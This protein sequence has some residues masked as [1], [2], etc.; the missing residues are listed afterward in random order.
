MT[1][2]VAALKKAEKISLDEA[3]CI[4]CDDNA[5]ENLDLIVKAGQGLVYKFIKLYGGVGNQ[6]MIQCAYEG[7]IKAAKRYDPVHGTRFS[8]WCS[9]YILGEIR[10]HNKK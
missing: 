5:K 9:H 10:H 4:Y 7:L 1:R 8:T 6:D 3:I 2:G